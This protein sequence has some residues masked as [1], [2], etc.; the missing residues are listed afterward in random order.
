MMNYKNILPI[1][2]LM[3]VLSSCSDNTTSANTTHNEA[4]EHNM[5]TVD[6]SSMAT[7]KADNAKAMA[8]KRTFEEKCVACH[9]SDG[10]AGIANAANLQTSK[11]DISSMINT[12]SNGRGGMPAFKS[13]LTEDEIENLASYAQTLR[14]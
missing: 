6:T 10:T 3:A 13:Q 12:I 9:G 11:L 5:S 4:T 1:L 14:K 2:V 8:G 7:E